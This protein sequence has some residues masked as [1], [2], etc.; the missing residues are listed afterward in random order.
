MS[1]PKTPEVIDKYVQFGTVRRVGQVK[2]IES[3]GLTAELAK[4]D[5]TIKTQL[6]VLDQQDEELKEQDK[7][8]DR[9][10][11]EVAE[12]AN[13]IQFLEAHIDTVVGSLLAHIDKEVQPKFSAAQQALDAMKGS[14]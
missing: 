7:E 13:R 11:A 12:K 8:I 3:D 9:L 14:K 10:R 5:E 4:K 1:D 6:T 2:G